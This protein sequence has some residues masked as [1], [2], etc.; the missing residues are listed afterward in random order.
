M[1]GATRTADSESSRWTAFDA[2]HRDEGVILNCGP[3][4]QGPVTPQALWVLEGFRSGRRPSRRELNECT[5]SRR[6]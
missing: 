6:R 5:W 1:G 3:W 2:R 4:S